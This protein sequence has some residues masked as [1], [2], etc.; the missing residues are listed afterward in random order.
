MTQPDQPNFLFL[1]TD[2][3]RADWL[4]CYGH[5]VLK[6]PNIDAIAAREV[7]DF[8]EL[9][10]ES[11]Q[12]G[13]TFLEELIA[14]SR[15]DLP[16]LRGPLRI[17][18]AFIHGPIRALPTTREGPGMS[19]LFSSCHFDDTVDFSGADFLS[20]RLVECTLP[21]FIGMSLTTK[22]DLDSSCEKVKVR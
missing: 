11:R 17:S 21:A 12:L 22:A 20:L 3:Q 18:G 2:Q 8:G 15:P 7:A 9:P 1:I 6:T 4:G 10:A 19:L 5:P 16:R 14:G 13:A